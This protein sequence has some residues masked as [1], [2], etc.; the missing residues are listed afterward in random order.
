MDKINFY[1]VNALI[2]TGE[3]LIG[4]EESSYSTEY[5]MTDE[6]FFPTASNGCLDKN[7]IDYFLKT[8]IEDES[9]SYS[10]NDIEESL[11]TSI[12]MEYYKLSLNLLLVSD[13]FIQTLI[14]IGF[15]DFSARSC[16]LHHKSTLRTWPNYWFLKYVYKIPHTNLVKGDEVCFIT[17]DSGPFY[18]QILKDQLEA[19]NMSAIHFTKHTFSIC[20]AVPMATDNEAEEKILQ[21]IGVLFLTKRPKVLIDSY[22]SVQYF[23]EKIL[24]TYSDVTSEKI[25]ALIQADPRQRYEIDPTD[26]HFIRLTSKSA[27]YHKLM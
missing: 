22:Y 4:D 9:E 7:S 17:Q 15:K 27:V 5:M 21:R 26:S 6:V 13:R 11:K 1:T 23:T 8:S 20:K 14:N 19:L 18:S 10:A 24:E 2:G 16:T 3:F 12:P 25:I